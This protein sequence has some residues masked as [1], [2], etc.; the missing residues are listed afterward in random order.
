MISG[1]VKLFS[2]SHILI[3]PPI[4]ILRFVWMFVKILGLLNMCALRMVTG[5]DLN[6]QCVH[7]FHSLIGSCCLVVVIYVFNPPCLPHA[8]HLPVIVQVCADDNEEKQTVDLEF[9]VDFATAD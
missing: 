3:H 6:L 2:V 7:P 4:W 1:L 8:L 5:Y 9:Q